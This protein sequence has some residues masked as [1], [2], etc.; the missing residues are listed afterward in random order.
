MEFEEETEFKKKLDEQKKKTNLQRQPRD[1]E[2]FANM[3]P[4][5]RDQQKEVWKKELEDVER[6]KDRAFFYFLLETL[7]LNKNLFAFYYFTT[8]LTFYFYFLLF[9]FYL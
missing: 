7:H 5:L 1:I 2:K 4:V 8:F 6:R 9:T 3:D